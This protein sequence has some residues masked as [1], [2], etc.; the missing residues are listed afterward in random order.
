VED[1]WDAIRDAL[2]AFTPAECA[3]YFTAA[4]YEPE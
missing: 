2:P 3:N 4:G 1:L